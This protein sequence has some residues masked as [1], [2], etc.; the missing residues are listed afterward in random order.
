MFNGSKIVDGYVCVEYQT[1]NEGS[2]ERI[3]W[4]FSWTIYFK[5]GLKRCEERIISSRHGSEVPTKFWKPDRKD[6]R[7][8]GSRAMEASGDKREFASRRIN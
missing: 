7:A 5:L 4:T 1:I 3:S 8:K 6:S 2:L